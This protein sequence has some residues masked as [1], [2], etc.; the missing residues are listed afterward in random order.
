MSETSPP[1]PER[2]PLLQRIRSHV[3][4]SRVQGIV[5]LL[6]ALLSIGGAVYGYLGY[7]RADMGEVVT[8]V[9]EAK[10][11]KPVADAMVEVLTAR[12][13]LVTTL[14]AS[15]GQARQRVKEGAYRVRVTH[16]RYGAETRQVQVIAGQTAEVRFRLAQRS[17]SPLDAAGKAVNEGV[18]SL[19]RILR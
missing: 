2:G 17:S 15:N 7:G 3:S 8:I 11:G 4:L 5:G 6:A 10:S 19:K 13:A 14:N 9:Q 1:Q 12:D 16:P 18:D